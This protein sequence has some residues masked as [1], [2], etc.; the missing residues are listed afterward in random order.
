MIK[1]I[2]VGLILL[3]IGLFTALVLVIRERNLAPEDSDA[4]IGGQLEDGYLATGFL[5]TF[6]SNSSIEYCGA[7]LL[8]STTAITAAHCLDKN[9]ARY[10]GLGEFTTD[11]RN[12]YPVA[13]I[14]QKAGWDRQTSNND[15]AMI[16]L[17]QSVPFSTL[18]RLEIISPV[19][20]CGY[21]VVAYGR[22]NP[23][24][25]T[26]DIDRE[27]KSAEICINNIIGDVIVMYSPKGGICLGDS[28][29]AIYIDRTNKMIGVVSA[30]RKPSDGS[31]TCFTGNTAFITRVDTGLEFVAEVVGQAKLVEFTSNADSN[32]VGVTSRSIN[33]NTNSASLGTNNSSQSVSRS[34]TSSV[35]S[36]Q[37]NSSQPSINLPQPNPSITASG[38]NQTDF[39]LLVLGI[40]ILATIGAI[41]YIGI[42]FRNHR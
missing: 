30:V 37:I 23:D 3:V 6:T 7:T 2:R 41:A 38:S 12:L 27:R 5:I 10:F 39:L 1:Y 35:S 13:N 22:D 14:Q 28:G 16:N 42:G 32:T 36:S 33:S 40:A 25:N 21:R 20:G 8:D 19:A 34:I 26:P 4:L 24:L 15:L 18:A 17:A 11:I 9:G 29:S 31:P